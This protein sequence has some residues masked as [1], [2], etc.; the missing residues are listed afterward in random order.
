MAVMAVYIQDLEPEVS[1][2]IKAE[3]PLPDHYPLA[4]NLYLIRTDLLT[5]AVA[6]RLGIREAAQTEVTATGAVFKLNAA[7]AGYANRAIWEWLDEH[8]P[9]DN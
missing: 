6:E 3:F 4:N 2:R 9:R 8:E 1:A 5:S 7:Y